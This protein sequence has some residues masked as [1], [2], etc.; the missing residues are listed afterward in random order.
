MFE[1]DK[2]GLCCK[3]ITNIKELVDFD[4]GDGICKHLNIDMNLCTIYHNRPDI[5]KVDTMYE[6]VYKEIYTKDEYYELNYEA[7]EFLKNIK[8]E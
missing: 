4:R 7:C 1:C 3:N 2:C 8:G 6:K 5:C